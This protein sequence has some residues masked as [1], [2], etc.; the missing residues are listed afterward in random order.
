MMKP[1][2][3]SG[4]EQRN[5]LIIGGELF[6]NSLVELA[7]NSYND[8]LRNP[9]FCFTRFI[10][11]GYNTHIRFIQGGIPMKKIVLRRDDGVN[12]IYFDFEKDFPML[13]CT[14]ID[15]AGGFTDCDGTADAE[16]IESV[17]EKIANLPHE[18]CDQYDYEYVRRLVEAWGIAG[19]S[20]IIPGRTLAT[21]IS[22]AS[23]ARRARAARMDALCIFRCAK[24][25][26][27]FAEA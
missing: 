15:D 7:A 26:A 13:G 12:N 14:F 18:S 24:R 1:T 8:L 9:V 3:R 25:A 21:S 11:R 17:E 22:S 27:C 2:R 6:A 5:A 20:R 10:A 23:G 16:W 4:K 19:K